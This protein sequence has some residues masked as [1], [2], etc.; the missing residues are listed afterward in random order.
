MSSS[1]YDLFGKDIKKYYSS[2]KN[3]VLNEKDTLSNEEEYKIYEI[4]ENIER[5]L[6]YCQRLKLNFG[7]VLDYNDLKKDGYSLDDIETFY[8][9]DIEFVNNVDDYFL[10]N[11][12]KRDYMFGYP[13]NMKD[14][15][16]ST[17]YLRYIEGKLYL[18][19]NCGD[20]YQVGNYRMDSKSVERN[21]ISLFAKNFGLNENEYWGY[22][23]S[24][25]TESNYWGIRQ[26]FSMFPKAKLYCSKDTHYSVQKFL[27][28][29]GSKSYYYSVVES[30]EDGSINCSKL[31]NSIC[32]DISKGINE[33]VLI[34]NWGTT[35]KGA[36]DDVKYITKFLIKNNIKYYCHLDAALYGGIP[37]NQLKAPVLKNIKKLNI[38]SIAISL[39]KFLG[40]SRVNGL[41]LSLNQVNNR[42]IDYIGQEDTT[43]LGSRDLAPF[44]TYQR[45]KEMLF[46]VNKNDFNNNVQYFENK[47]NSNCIWHFK[48]DKSNIFILKKPSDYIC[49]KYQLAT[50]NDAD[51]SQKCHIIIFPFHKKYVIDELVDDIRG[52][53]YE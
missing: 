41:L 5:Y 6:N 31:I 36:I 4:V 19:N 35:C 8:Q 14:Y 47:L 24:G 30:N 16:Y 26:G 33:F 13:A 1:F 40:T 7:Q 3:K 20:P 17:Q 25:G 44:S 48:N 37:H 34:L 21:I 50:F 10:D 39:H 23:T 49:K 32:L 28:E 12:K 29:N 22:L 46:R 51:G 9:E 43:I 18:M 15:S 11:K 27:D 52:E 53:C 2:V 38:N 42:V 45:T